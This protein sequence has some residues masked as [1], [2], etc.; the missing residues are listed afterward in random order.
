MHYNWHRHYD[1]SLGRYTQ[2]DP[3]GF[4]DGPSVYGYARGNPY[5]YVD[6]RGLDTDALTDPLIIGG[7][8]MIVIAG[9]EIY[10]QCKKLVRDWTDPPPPPDN[11]NC[12]PGYCCFTHETGQS[13]SVQDLMRG[14]WGNRQCHY[15]CADPDEN[16]NIFQSKPIAT[17]APCPLMIVDD[18]NSGR[19]EGR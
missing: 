11:D 3:L 14:K 19:I 5:G 17:S 10:N 9:Q 7:I 15:K 18:W 16:G 6:P 1:P 8:T 2:T 12:P 4:V 13:V